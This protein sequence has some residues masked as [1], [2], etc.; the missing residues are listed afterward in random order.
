MKDVQVFDNFE[1]MLNSCNLDVIYITTPVDSHIPIAIACVKK[2]L[3]FFVEKPLSKN[4][5][6]GRKLVNEL[7]D[8]DVIT[9][10]GYYL[11]F[12]PTFAKVKKMLDEKIIGDIIYVNSSIYLSQLFR[13]SS[14]WRFRKSEGGGGVLLD[15]GVHLIDLLLWYFG[16]VESVIGTTKSYYSNEVEDFAHATL[17][18]Q[19][20]L[21]TNTD[22]SWSVRNHRLQETTI[23]IHGSNGM[24]KVN[25]DYIRMTLNESSSG[26]KSGNTVIY[27]QSIPDGVSID[28]GGP[29]YTKEDEYFI[30]CI[31]N[32]KK[33]MIGIV[34]AI[35][36]QSVIDAIYNST[37]KHTFEKVNYLK[38]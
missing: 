10:V 38:Y 6:E 19:S 24:I 16:S 33:S 34:E 5:D 30:N 25:D 35:A 23:E 3:N 26:F 21:V 18:F 1:N 4:T 29:E 20:G 11:R 9:S 14:G 12:M 28:I 22:V 17:K 32:G 7:R 36:T 37:K 31:R 2:K 27:K 13:K 15:L 8:N